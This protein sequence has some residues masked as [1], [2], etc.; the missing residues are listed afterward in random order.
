MAQ[1]EIP[2]RRS[3]PSGDEGEEKEEHH[4]KLLEVYKQ[5]AALEALRSRLRE[6]PSVYLHSAQEVHEL[7][8]KLE[9]TSNKLKEAAERLGRTERPLA[10]EAEEEQKLLL[11]LWDAKSELYVQAVQLWAERKPLT[12]SR[13]IGRRLGTKLSKK[14]QKAIQSRR[15]PITKL[16][17]NYNTQF[18]QYV[19]KFPRQRVADADNHPLTYKNFSS[20]PIDHKFWNDGIYYHLKAPWAI[21]PDVRTGITCLLVLE[22]VDEE[23]DLI[24]QEMARSMSWGLAMYRHMKD[25]IQYIRARQ[26]ALENEFDLTED[27]IDNLD[28]GDIS[29]AEKLRLISKELQS[30]LSAHGTLMLEWTETVTWM[31]ARCQPNLLRTQ[32]SEWT[33]LIAEILKDQSVRRPKRGQADVVVDNDGEEAILGVQVDD[34]EEDSSDPE[35]AWEDVDEAH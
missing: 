34:G 13:T 14:I 19:A 17:A 27:H 25:F 20:M 1:K 16:I 28:L 21:E 2:S 5:E 15:G 23:I 29:R 24:T 33:N 18:D 35:G 11:L 26:A 31:C 32:Y 22:R 4:S 6:N 10:D 7:L 30:C 12:D 3:P 9:D 8:D